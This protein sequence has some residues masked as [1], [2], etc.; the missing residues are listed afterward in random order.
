MNVM[1]MVK[2]FFF[3]PRQ[4]MGLFIL[5]IKVM[6]GMKFGLALYSFLRALRVLR[7]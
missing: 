2:P 3:N 5:T 6:K 1:F 7:G 4:G